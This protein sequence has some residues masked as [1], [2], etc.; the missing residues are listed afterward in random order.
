MGSRLSIV[1][2]LM[3]VALCGCGP[4][5]RIDQQFAEAPDRTEAQ[6]RQDR[7][8]CMT[9][10]DKLTNFIACMEARGYRHVK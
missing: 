4:G 7:Y 1:V 2:G 5:K 8:E 6:F 10:H 9:K 3:L